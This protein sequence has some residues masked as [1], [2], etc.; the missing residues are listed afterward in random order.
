MLATNATA[1]HVGDS[2]LLQVGLRDDGMAPLTVTSR[3]PWHGSKLIITDQA[4]QQV[5][6]THDTDPSD[7]L[8]MHFLDLKPGKTVYLGFMLRTWNDISSWGYTLT[9][10]GIYKIVGIPLV[11]GAYVADDDTT[12]RSNVVTI[13]ILP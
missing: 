6:P 7:F 3:T 13:T 4:G 5:V 1:Y 12:I 10:P 9:K 2:I 8:T 11:N